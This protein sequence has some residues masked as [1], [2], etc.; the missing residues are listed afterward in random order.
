[1][2]TADIARVPS[3]KFPA[4]SSV[5]IYRLPG[6]GGFLRAEAVS[7]D[8]TQ[9]GALSLLGPFVAA[10]WPLDWSEFW[11]EIT[12]DHGRCLRGENNALGIA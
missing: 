7:P 1:M 6:G 12:Y 11:L 3:N 2:K 9:G 8:R 10:R 4:K 5:A